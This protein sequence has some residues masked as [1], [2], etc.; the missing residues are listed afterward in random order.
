M[1]ITQGGKIIGIHITNV[2]NQRFCDYISP[3]DAVIKRLSATK[4]YGNTFGKRWMSMWT[5][6]N[7][8]KWPGSGL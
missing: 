4:P 7:Q 2:V 6:A 8:M 1:S 3:W 5:A